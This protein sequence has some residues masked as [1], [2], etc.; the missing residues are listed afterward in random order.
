MPL[1]WC[2]YEVRQQYRKLLCESCGYTSDIDTM[3][4]NEEGNTTSSEEY[5]NSTHNTSY[6]S[7]VNQYV[8]NNCGAVLI[9]EPDTTATSCNFC[10]APVV[11][12]DRLSGESSPYYIIPF[13]ISKTQAQEAFKNGVKTADLLQKVS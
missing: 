2:G 13:Q 8:C 3:K 12:A 4:R 5:S 6:E 9:T 10:G 7:K 11:L 1:L